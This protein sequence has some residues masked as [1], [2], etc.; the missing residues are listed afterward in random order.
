ML[1][2]I[3]ALM[4]PVAGIVDKVLDRVIPDPEQREAAKREMVKLEQEGAFRDNE[5]QLSAILAEANSADPWTS[6]ARPSFLYV[7]Y[8]M[9]LASIPYGIVYAVNPEVAGNVAEGV[10][11]WFRA[12]PNALYT[13]FGAGFLGYTGGRSFDKWQKAKYSANGGNVYG[14]R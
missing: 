3:T 1:P 5:I 11:A 6:R 7:M 14:F 13:L 8:V 9:I 10:G 2:V 12:I 4:G